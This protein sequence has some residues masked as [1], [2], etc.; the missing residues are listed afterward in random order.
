MNFFEA[1]RVALSGLL[2]NRM[3]AILTTLGIIIGVAAV[4]SLVALGRGVENYIASEFE[5][6]GSNLLIVIPQAPTNPDRTRREPLT[7][8][9]ARD[10]LDPSI[11]PSIAD[12]AVSF[13]TVGNV[14]S[15]SESYATNIVGV[16][17]NIL[18]V[19]SWSVVP[20]G[21]FFTQEDLDT[22]ARVT[23][24][25]T[26][27][28]EELY[29]DK[30]YDPVG[31]VVRINERPFTVIGVLG[32]TGSALLS[33]D[34]YAYV[35][36]TTA[37]TRLANA[38]A[39]DGS[40]RVTSFW[41][42]AVSKERMDQATAEIEAYMREAHN[43]VFDGDE[44]YA[45]ANQQDILN[46]VGQITGLL[47]VVLGLIAGI[48]LVVGG[49]GIMNIMLV[50]VTERTREIGLRKAVG[51]RGQD[52]MIQFLIESVVLSILGGL[53]G[54]GLS[55]VAI[56]VA[57]QA[58][59]DLKLALTTDAVLLATGVSS[60]VGVFFGLYPASRA[61]VMRPIDALRFE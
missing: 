10:L 49:I 43:V 30:T 33:D 56:V 2:S 12:L 18:S 34:D 54:V 27:V 19:R 17:P 32:E 44:D 15:G 1:F 47:T 59:P 57:G 45:V 7:T 29:G 61:A 5:D 35:P 58:L 40:Y 11:A 52:I 41:I 46:T 23:V 53:L 42:N 20:G 51:A 4:I 14:K 28:V 25:G 48:S 26:G 60:F 22:T 31:E 50:S 8:R 6:L 36:L 21:Q 16:S 37:Q 3:R 13:Q 39:S 38:R 55:F 24:L 9:E